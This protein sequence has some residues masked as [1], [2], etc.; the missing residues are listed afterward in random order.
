MSE[1]EWLSATSLYHLLS[2]GVPLLPRKRL[3][4]GVACCRWAAE[5]VDDPDI[6]DAIEAA[7]LAA[8]DEW[9]RTQLAAVRRL[10]LRRDDPALGWHTEHQHAHALASA[11]LTLLEE[12]NSLAQAVSY[13]TWAVHEGWG[14]DRHQTTLFREVVGNPFRPVAFD[15]AWQTPTVLALADG[16][17]A[18]RAFDR[19][20]VLADAL[21]DAGCDAADLL[22]HLRGPG[23]H[24]RGCW[25][26]DLVLGNS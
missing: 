3:L 16:V 4:F 9:P 12:P 19:L 11:V 7:E 5:H 6:P 1:A 24:V 8:D 25:A 15:P 26:L 18:G 14:T 17:Y 21:E 22:A 23:P 13:C 10:Y 20:P 2:A